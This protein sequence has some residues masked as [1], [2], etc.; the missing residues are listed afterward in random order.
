MSF[1]YEVKQELSRIF[2]PKNCCQKAELLALIYMSGSIRLVGGFKFAKFQIKTENASTIRKAYKLLKKY[3]SSNIE[4]RVLKNNLLKKNNLYILSVDYKEI[5]TFFKRFNTRISATK[6]QDLWPSPISIRGDCCRQAY[7]RGA[8][9]GSGSI[10]DPKKAYH[11]EITTT[12]KK[13]AWEIV[14]IFQG[15]S[16]V[17][18]INKTK[19]GFKVYIKDGD[20]IFE[21]LGLI[22]AHNSLLKFEDIRVVKDVRNNVNRMVNCETANLSKTIDASICNI[23]SIKYLK[24]IDKYEDLP[25]NLKEIA[26]LRLEY[27]DYSLKE[28]GQ[29]LTPALGKSGVNYRLN[30]ICKIAQD[31]KT[32]KGEENH[33]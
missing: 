5:K 28:L 30:K 26:E 19:N 32:M 13:R 21:V 22:G 27:P 1:S 6:S 4:T 20:S 11:L 24:S 33:D 18:K 2:P 23:N 12:N 25:K 29:M 7:L 3:V 8:F 9:L 10:S 16:V 31:Y 17:A 14:E 15:F